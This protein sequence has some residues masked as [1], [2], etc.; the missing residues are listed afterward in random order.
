M[1][2]L[3]WKRLSAGVTVI[4]VALLVA[5]NAYATP[6]NP[7]RVFAAADLTLPSTAPNLP[8]KIFVV[9]Q[10]DGLPNR[11]EGTL[12]LF[13][14]PN[15]CATRSV[16]VSGTL[17]TNPTAVSQ[18][19]T[20]TGETPPDPCVG[21]GPAVVRIVIGPALAPPDPCLLTFHFPSGKTATYAGKTISFIVG[22]I[23]TTTSTTS[24]S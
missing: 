17:F 18:N 6:P 8:S 16:F 15:S 1:L 5:S 13:Y 23:T 21:L 19:L 11:L 9:I 24:P 7:M 20:F 12:F 14:P 22:T 3:A 2:R 10:A 4:L